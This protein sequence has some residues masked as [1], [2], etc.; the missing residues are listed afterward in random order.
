MMFFYFRMRLTCVSS[1]LLLFVCSCESSFEGREGACCDSGELLEAIRVGGR[2]LILDGS[3]PSD[4]C[5]NGSRPRP[6]SASGAETREVVTRGCLGHDVSLGCG[7]L[8]LFGFA[9]QIS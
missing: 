3:R 6:P 7:S 9:G 4:C 2:R 1:H 5:R 8:H